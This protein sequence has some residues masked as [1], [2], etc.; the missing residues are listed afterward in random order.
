MQ[1]LY[2]QMFFGFGFGFGFGSVAVSAGDRLNTLDFPLR[3]LV[4]GHSPLRHLCV[5]IPTQHLLAKIN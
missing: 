3:A 1:N 4:I 2:G 5:S